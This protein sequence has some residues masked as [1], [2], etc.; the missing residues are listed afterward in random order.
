MS[1][2][3]SAGNLSVSGNFS[4]AGNVNLSSQLTSSANGYFNSL[5]TSSINSSSGEFIT[6]TEN[7]VSLSSKYVDFSSDQT[8]TGPKNFYSIQ[9]NGTTLESKY[10][11]FSSGQ[12]IT[13]SKTFTNITGVKWGNDTP[14]VIVPFYVLDVNNTGLIFAPC[15]T[16]GAFNG[17]LV[18]ENDS[19]LLYQR[20]G[21]SFPT[22]G[23]VIAPWGSGGI[24]ISSSGLTVDGNVYVNNSIGIGTTTPEYSLD[25]TG[26][27]RFTDD[28]RVSKK[29]YIG[30]NNPGGGGGDNV[31]MEYVAISGDNTTLRIN[32]NNDSGDNINLNPTGNVGVKMDSPAYPLD[33][34]GSI[35][36]SGSLYKN[37]V[38]VLSNYVDLSST[39]TISGSKTFTNETRVKMS[40]SMIPFFVQDNNNSGLMFSP[41]LTLNA[42]N[43]ELVQADDSG[44]FYQ[45]NGAS[46]PSSGLVIGPWGNK[47]IIIGSSN[48]RI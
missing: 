35:N 22:S 39:Q 45:Q 40:S 13:G 21:T 7:G 29:L 5:T 25:V 41:C 32:V 8:I 1:N 30:V 10:V 3:S 46:Y 43:W 34:N 4:C 14:S 9:E 12:T 38:S 11:D 18:Q 47:K 28:V 24:R 31:F 15:L 17:G 37:G 42:Y 44:I 36:F 48:N 2:L 6:I 26:T 20:N 27:A 16:S 33:V 19:A 23:L